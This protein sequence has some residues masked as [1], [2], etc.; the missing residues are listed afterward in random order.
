MARIVA[1]LLTS[2]A[3]VVGAVTF[4]ATAEGVSEPRRVVA[5]DGFGWNAGSVTNDDGFG[6]G[7]PQGD[8]GATRQV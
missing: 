3:L 7:S 5:D 2:A 6:W 4:G 1:P 8:S